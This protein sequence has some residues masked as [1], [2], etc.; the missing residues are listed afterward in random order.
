MKADKEQLQPYEHTG[1]SRCFGCGTESELGLRLRF[2]LAPNDTIVSL[3]T[4]PCAYDSHPGILH[5]GIISTLLDEVMS[6]AV[7]IHGKPSMTRTMEIEYLRPAPSGSPLRIEGRVT[8][9]EG[10]K[11]WT[12]ARVLNEAGEVLAHGKALFIEVKQP[13]KK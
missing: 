13:A 7:R 3:I 8:R 10:R 6:K 5:G 11:H 2:C 9:N 4:V 12:D 1:Y